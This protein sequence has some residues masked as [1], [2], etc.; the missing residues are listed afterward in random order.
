M[1]NSGD[2]LTHYRLVERVGADRR[3]VWDAVDTRDDRPVTL[4][5][6]PHLKDCS[7]NLSRPA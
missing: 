3:E 7:Q 4:K 5:V 6:L 1:R 2:Q